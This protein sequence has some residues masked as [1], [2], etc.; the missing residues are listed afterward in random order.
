LYTVQS[1][2]DISEFQTQTCD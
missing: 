2:D 1:L